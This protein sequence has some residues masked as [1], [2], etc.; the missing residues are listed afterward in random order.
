MKILIRELSK[1]LAAKTIDRTN[2]TSITNNFTDF[3]LR[4]QN[5]QNLRDI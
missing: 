3:S 4:K 5:H 2:S 1:V